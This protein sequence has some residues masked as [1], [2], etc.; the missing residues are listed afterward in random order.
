M[1]FEVG[2][3]RGKF[4]AARFLRNPVG[5]TSWC[6]ERCRRSG[7]VRRTGLARAG[8][9]QIQTVLYHENQPN[10]AA[11]GQKITIP[12]I[13]EGA[14]GNPGDI[15]KFAFAV[16]AGEKLAFEIETPD[17]QPPEFNPRLSV[18]D[19]QDS[20]LFS[21][22]YRRIAL[23]NNNSDRV[24]Y[25]QNVVAKSLYTFDNGRHLCPSGARHYFAIRRAALSVPNP[26]SATNSACG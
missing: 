15:D 17:Q 23:F 12:A 8:R 20:E 4:A 2:V 16:K 11:E 9:S 7:S 25:W 22:L 6:D 18:E 14:I 3:T 1:G 21:N 26:N 24:P 10:A 5:R 13:V 19:A